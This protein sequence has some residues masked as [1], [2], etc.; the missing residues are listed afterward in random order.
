[1]TDGQGSASAAKRRGGRQV[2]AREQARLKAAQYT[3]QESRRQEIA[4]RWLLA[5][6]DVAE[7]AAAVERRIAAERVKLERRLE[8]LRTALEEPIA[9]LRTDADSLVLDLLGTGVTQQE[10]AGRLGISAAE[11]GRVKRERDRAGSPDDSAPAGGTGRA[12]PPTGQV[13]QQP[14]EA[15]RPVISA[16]LGAESSPAVG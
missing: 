16:V 2:A 4:T 15:E 3:A 10:A 9:K 1:M 11:V 7:R 13:P 12:V 5:Q 14:G 6:E 8:E